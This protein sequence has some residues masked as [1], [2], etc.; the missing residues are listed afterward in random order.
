MYI[1][2]QKQRIEQLAKDGYVFEYEK[3]F[4][5]GWALFRKGAGQYVLYSLLY[6][7]ISFG[8]G[9]IPIL[10][11]FAAIVVGP[12][13]A[14]GYYVASKKLN[15]EGSIEIGDF[16]KSFDFVLQLCILGIVGG[17]IT[18]FLV[19]F[20][21][22][23]AIWFA[24]ATSLASL[25]VVFFKTDFWDSIKLSLKIVNKKWFHWL[26]LFLLLGLLNIAGAIA[27]GI[28]LFITIPTSY[29]IIFCAYQHIVGF[30]EGKKDMDTSEHLVD[31]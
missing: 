12:A 2:D 29:C 10:G 7:A 5:S 27:L 30:D 8:L 6:L 22:L 14:A 25:F 16:F 17:I 21:V 23:P 20:L 9:I 26:G 15:D 11:F 13:L 18:V 31:F 24:V 4:S 3:Y 28:G 1:V 19:F